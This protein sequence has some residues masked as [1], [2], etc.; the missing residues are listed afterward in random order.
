MTGTG[1]GQS[2]KDFSHVLR[3]CYQQATQALHAIELDYRIA[4][5]NVRLC[6]AGPSLIPLLTPALAH[7]AQSAVA[8]RPDF[9][10]LLWDSASTQVPLSLQSWQQRPY[11]QQE[12]QGETPSY[13]L[14][15]SAGRSKALVSLEGHC[16]SLIDLDEN[17]AVFWVRRVTDV[18]IYERAAP[19]RTLW[20]WW[21]CEQGQPLVHAGAVAS[22]ENAAL[23]V[24]HSGAG[25]STTA[26]SCLASGLDYLSDDYCMVSLQPE[27]SVHSL[28]NSAKLEARHLQQRLPELAA[29]IKNRDELQ[30][31][32]AVVSVYEAYPQQMR[33]Q[34]LIKAM[35]LPV[36]T[37]TDRPRLTPVSSFAALHAF[38]PSSLLQLPGFAQADLSRLTR[39]V[40][41]CACYRL[42]LG[43][44]LGKSALLI[45]RLLES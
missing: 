20:H 41:Q 35:I 45:R 31:E 25:K 43:T 6:F 14:N 27:A 11:R 34:A 29:Y 9:T 5:Y 13:Y 32:K 4:G 22:G 18:P 30:N 10:V 40:R 44:D 15:D 1:T 38:A 21:L 26:L 16:L 28:F 37:A 24:G 8:V 17:L 19:L 7:L 2:L 42:E 36:Q 23:I 39:L 33:L 3:A 12:L